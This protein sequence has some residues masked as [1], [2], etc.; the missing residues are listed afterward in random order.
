MPGELSQAEPQ[1]LEKLT[2][3]YLQDWITAQTAAAKAESQGRPAAGSCPGVAEEA[4]TILA[5]EPPYDI[6]V[7]WKPLEE[8]P[9]GWN[10]DLNDG[11]R[12][13]IRPFMTAEVLC[14]K[15]SINWVK[16]GGNEPPR[17]LGALSVVLEKRQIHR[18]PHQ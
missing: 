4:E 17:D 1:V 3:S 10:P 8:Q 16:D 18:R 14:K 5:G 7:R 13:N 12:M 6:F 15:P 9:I 2:Y 11:V